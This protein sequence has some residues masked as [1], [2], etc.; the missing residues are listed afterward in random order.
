MHRQNIL[1]I[2]SGIHAQQAHKTIAKQAGAREQNHGQRELQD[3]E[4]FVRHVACA[5]GGN[6]SCFFERGIQVRFDSCERGNQP[7]QQTGQHGNQQRENENA[8]IKIDSDEFRNIFC[9][10]GNNEGA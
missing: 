8:P 10:R 3:D 5:T 9:V 2:K 7:K 6:C 4:T 1:G